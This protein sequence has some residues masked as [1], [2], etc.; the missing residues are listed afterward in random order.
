MQSVKTKKIIATSTVQTKSGK[1]SAP[2]EHEG[3]VNCL[4]DLKN[5][6]VSVN[7]ISTDRNKQI[8]KWLREKCP[9][10]RHCYDPWHFAKNIKGKIRPIAKKKDN[11]IIEDWIKPIGTHLFYCSENCGNDGKKLVEMWKSLLHHVSNRHTFKSNKLYKKCDHGTLSKEEAKRR[12]WIKKGTPAFIEL[13]KVVCDEKYLKD[14]PQLAGADHTGN[15]EVFNSVL[16][17]Y[18]P[19]RIEFDHRYMDARVKLA[20]LDFNENIGRNQAVIK[21]PNKPSGRMGQKRFRFHMAKQSNEW[22]AKE[23]KEQKTH[24]FVEE[25]FEEIFRLK[26]SG[27]KISSAAPKDTNIPQNIAQTARPEKDEIL[28]KRVKVT[29]FA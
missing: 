17:A 27:V 9:N 26:N 15:V 25:L 29:R 20:V 8:A 28:K 19:K 22:V 7:K 3:F 24:N 11:Q 2:L 6:G 13:E 21:T 18:A 4:A 12:K 16:L 14:M 10:I 5:D 1:G 23:V